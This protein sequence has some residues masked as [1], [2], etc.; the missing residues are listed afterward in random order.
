M[1]ITE[2]T[3]CGKS[4]LAS[5]LGNRTSYQGYKVAYFNHQ[6][7]LNKIKKARLEGI[8]LKFFEKLAKTDLLIL[9]DFGLSTFGQQR[10]LY[11]MELTEDR[12]TRLTTIIASQ[13][14]IASWCDLFA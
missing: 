5:A 9:D 11:L 3:G 7:L 13:L 14:P 10:C 1:L 2:A 12:H 8:N 4:F 6:E